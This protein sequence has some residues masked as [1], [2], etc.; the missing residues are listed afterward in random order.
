AQDFE[1]AIHAGRLHGPVAA[2][3]SAELRAIAG[4]QFFD[5]VAIILGGKQAEVAAVAAHRSGSG[6]L[7]ASALR[8]EPSRDGPRTWRCAGV[9][10]ARSTPALKPRFIAYN[11]ARI[12]AT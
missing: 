1:L 6:V 7:A 5:R 4:R 10:Y 9:F 2:Q 3:V 8:N 12:P 11:M